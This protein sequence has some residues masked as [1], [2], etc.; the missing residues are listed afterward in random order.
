MKHRLTCKEFIAF[1]DD[2]FAGTQ[3]VEIRE[4]FDS[5][6][7][8]CADCTAY[9]ET[10]RQTVKLSRDAFSSTEDDLQAD[11]PDRLIRAITAAIGQR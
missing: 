1:L 2:Y 4:T 6:L 8:S 10:Y 7:R 9:L 3:P 11:V 5:H